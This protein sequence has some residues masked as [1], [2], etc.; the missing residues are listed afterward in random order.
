[1]RPLCFSDIARNGNRGS[2]KADQVF[3]RPPLTGLI[4]GFWKSYFRITGHP[5]L[6]PERGILRGGKPAL[7]FLIGGPIGSWTGWCREKDRG[8]FV[9]TP[10]REDPIIHDTHHILREAGTIMGIGSPFLDCN[11]S[12]FRYF[13]GSQPGIRPAETIPHA[14]YL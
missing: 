6:N 5:V 12:F 8:P 1:M 13:P 4:R 7:L 9:H 10:Q 3:G 14:H 11:P 2:I